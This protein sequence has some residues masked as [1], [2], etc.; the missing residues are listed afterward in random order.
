VALHTWF[1]PTLFVVVSALFFAAWAGRSAARDVA[2][3]AA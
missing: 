3:P 2:P 1:V